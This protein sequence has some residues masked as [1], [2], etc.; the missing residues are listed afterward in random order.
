MADISANLYQWSATAASNNPSG[1]TTIG[2]GLDD[3][4]RQIQATV[5]GD[6]ASKGSDI[7]SATTTDLGAVVGLMHDITGTTTITGLGTVSAGVWKIIKFE[8][9]LTLT[10]NATSL[11]LPGAGNITTV[12]GD[13]GI[14]MSEG[15]GN[16][17]CLAWLPTSMSYYEKGTKAV[18]FAASTSGTITILSTADTVTY[19]KVG[20]D[21]T[22]RGR[23][24]VTSVSSPV[25]IWQIVGLPFTSA[26]AAQAGLT[27][28]GSPTA[29]GSVYIESLATAYTNTAIIFLDANSSTAEI[30]LAGTTGAGTATAAQVQAG[31]VLHFCLSYITNP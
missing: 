24:E 28:E 2:T 18:T 11:I 21:V 16:W 29:V 30:R 26:T 22:V 1:T 9:A 4:L 12:A 10:H 13:V 27:G 8:G 5:R 6:L 14:F 23:V 7:A 19:S 20:R 25:G 17:R 15:S 3:N 31:T